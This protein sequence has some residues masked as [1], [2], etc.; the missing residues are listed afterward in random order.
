MKG[1]ILRRFGFRVIGS[2]LAPLVLDIAE[3]R[4]LDISN[5]LSNTFSLTGL[6]RA[7]LVFCC[8]MIL[9]ELLT[10]VFARE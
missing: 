4:C 10:W 8:T 5:L 2:W 3:C 7:A 9:V 6:G 1:Y